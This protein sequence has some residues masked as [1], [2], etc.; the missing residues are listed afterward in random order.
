MPLT[1]AHRERITRFVPAFRRFL[2]N[3]EQEDEVLARQARFALYETLLAPE[4]LRGMT[5]LELGQIVASLWASRQWGNKSYLVEKLIMQNG[6]AAIGSHLK[7][8]LWGN[9]E[10]GRRYDAFR[11]AIKGLGAASI[12]ELLAFCHPDQC[13][14]WNDTARQ[15]LA[16]LGLDDMLPAVRKAQINGGEYRQFNALL[17]EM[18][19]FLT[20]HGIEG[21]NTLD[22]NAFLYLVWEIGRESE[23]LPRQAAVSPPEEDFDHDEL[24]EQL[25]NVGQWLGFVAEKEKTVARGAK[26]DLIWQ[27]RIANLGV[28]TYVF[29]VQR[30]GSVDSLILNLQRAQNNPTVQRLIVVARG[31][32]IERIRGEIVTLPE[33][34]RKS[35]SYMVVRDAQRAAELIGELSGIIGKLELVRSEFGV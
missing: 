5:E 8:L 19:D 16:V 1:D 30:R 12:T 3:Y 10:I 31:D 26:V 4:N 21:L 7:A 34:F 18:R 35:V 23:P 14:V 29:E 11:K 20:W 13:G 15:A 33:S 24:V 2:D 25:V 32:D 9:E 28:V 6:L 22:L 17:H 27:A